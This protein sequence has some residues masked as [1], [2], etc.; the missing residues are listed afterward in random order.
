MIDTSKRYRTSHME[1]AVFLLS[2]DVPL[3]G[4]EM[5]G[6]A[7]QFIFDIDRNEADSRETAFASGALVPV[8]KLFASLRTIRA[9]IRQQQDTNQ[10]FTGAS[11]RQC[12]KFSTSHSR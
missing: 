8:T 3:V 5:Q 4:T 1:M 2:E 12:H 11:F 6:H 7:L 9:I 10:K